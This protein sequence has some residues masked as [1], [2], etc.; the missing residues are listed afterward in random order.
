MGAKL[1]PLLF[2]GRGEKPGLADHFSGLHAELARHEGGLEAMLHLIQED[3]RLST[4]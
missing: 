4:F 3:L 2:G 1:L